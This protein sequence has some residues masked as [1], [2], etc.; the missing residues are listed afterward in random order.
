[1]GVNRNEWVSRARADRAARTVKNVELARDGGRPQGRGLSWARLAVA[2]TAAVTL[3]CA[4]PA[5]ANAD[6]HYTLTDIGQI[7]ARAMNASDHV[8]GTG[9]FGTPGL[10][11]DGSTLRQ[12]CALQMA[13]GINGNDIV[14]GSGNFRVKGKTVTHAA[15]CSGTTMVDLGTLGGDG[16][17]AEDINGA[18]QVVGV[19]YTASQA[20]HAFLYSG[21]SMHDLGL[22][23][24]VTE[25]RANAVNA[26]GQVVGWG[27]AG[28]PAPPARAFLYDGALLHELGPLPGASNTLAWD[29]NDRG[30]V[31]GGSGGHPYLYTSGVTIDLGLPAAATGGSAYA[32]NNIG[33]IVGT[34]GTPSGDRAFVYE[35][36]AFTDLNDLIPAGTGWILTAAWDINDRGDILA[37]A[38]DATGVLHGLIL[39]ILPLY[40]YEPQLRLDSSENFYPDSAAEVTDNYVAGQYTNR[41]LD[42]SQNLIAASDPSYGVGVLSL[43]Y[44]GGSYPGGALSQSS[45]HIDEADSYG[46]DAYRLHENPAYANKIYGRV[47]SLGNGETLLQYWFSYYYNS[48]PFDDHEGDWEMIQVHLDVNGSPVRAAY[49]QHNGGERCDWTH[50]QR[51]QSGRPIVYV[52]V[53]S[54]ASFFSSGTH[55]WSAGA[56]ADYTDGSAHIDPSV[57]DVDSAPSWLSWP[58]I[59]GGSGSSPVGPAL[60]DSQWNHGLD[61]ENGVSGCTES[62]TYTATRIVSGSQREGRSAPPSPPPVPELTARLVGK[63][64]YITYRFSEMPSGARAP[65]QLLLSARSLQHNAPAL[66]KWV[67]IRARKGTVSEDVSVIHGSFTIHAIIFTKAGGHT[68]LL[69]IPLRRG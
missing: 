28:G 13:A 35:D 58:G 52:A 15:T 16:S 63:R 12:A 53:G 65:W 31:V 5:L 17:S 57:I 41:L 27:D 51:T 22:L 21:G 37:A 19:S 60:H 26:S 54:H 24:G 66:S 68:P 61:W 69:S 43:D 49:S 50:V 8:A 30:D 46:T 47:I 1:M 45:D 40:R 23:V 6:P 20:E 42:G 4:A 33:D 2:G 44:L 62:Q 38:R 64:V 39:R 59:W 7:D 56:A 18:G 14:A 36:G 55:V 34:A 9:F 48:H 10:I 11:Y 25:M 32:I 29:I 3:A 67:Q